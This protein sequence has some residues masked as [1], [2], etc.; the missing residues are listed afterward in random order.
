MPSW[1]DWTP[2]PDPREND[3]LYA[4]FGPGVYELRRVDTKQ[5]VLRGKGQNCAYRMTSL[6]PAPFGQGTRKNI[7][8]REYV[9]AN[10][11]QI[12]YRTCSCETKGDAKRLEAK[13]NRDD[14]GLFPT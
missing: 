2:F 13:L 11:K 5:L 14:P 10:L 8:K 3:Y 9:L 4:P 1:S 7:S 12:E 6:L